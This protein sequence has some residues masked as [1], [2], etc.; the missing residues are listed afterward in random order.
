MVRA[1]VL[2]LAV[3]LGSAWCQQGT[4]GSSGDELFAAGKFA[5]AAEADRGAIKAATE[6]VGAQAGLVR[7]LLRLDRAD[8]A[9]EAATKALAAHPDAAAL[10]AAMGDVHFRRG[11]MNEAEVSYIAAY[12]A[13]KTN[14]RALWGLARPYGASVQY[15]EAVGSGGDQ[16]RRHGR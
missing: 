12:K 7:A 6:A 11:E 1:A 3:G 5:E 2:V 15:R 14:A 9:N 10:M 8:E 4:G 16:V 13:D